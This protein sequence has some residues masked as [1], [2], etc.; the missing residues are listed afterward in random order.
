MPIP[1]VLVTRF[2]QLLV[3]RQFA[4]AEREL[5]RIK[6][7]M[8]K[9]EWNR[10]YYR[11]LRGMWIAYKSTGDEYTFLPKLNFNDKKALQNYRKE[12]RAHVKSKLHEDFDRGFFSAW[13]ECM[14][15]LIKSAVDNPET[16]HEQTENE[17]TKTVGNGKN[18]AKIESYL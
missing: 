5:Q 7:K 14:R 18:Q 4:E 1:S 12:F 10:G 9:T 3:E 16:K 6:Q 17:K 11:A 13:S 2:F 15:V 8:H